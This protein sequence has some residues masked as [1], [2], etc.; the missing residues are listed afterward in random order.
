MRSN[1][2]E[3]PNGVGAGRP[4]TAGSKPGPG[5]GARRIGRPVGAQREPARVSSTASF[6]GLGGIAKPTS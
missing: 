1:W 4:Y 6:T 5:G 3:A 2:L